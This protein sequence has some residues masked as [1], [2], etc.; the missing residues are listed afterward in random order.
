MT[1]LP[2]FGSFIP[3]TSSYLAT[4]SIQRPA[5]ASSVSIFST[6]DSRPQSEYYWNGSVIEEPKE[7]E[8]VANI[9]AGMKSKKVALG[10][11]KVSPLRRIR[12]FGS[13]SDDDSNGIE[14][15]FSDS[16]DLCMKQSP[17]FLGEKKK[18]FAH[19]PKRSSSFHEKSSDGEEKLGSPVS[20]FDAEEISA[21]DGDD[22]EQIQDSSDESIFRQSYSDF[23]KNFQETR[24]RMQDDL[25][26]S[27][28]LKRRFH[29]TPFATIACEYHTQLHARCP[30]N[31][32]ERR[33]AR[34]HP[35]S[36]KAKV[37]EE[38][39]VVE[40][41]KQDTLRSSDSEMPL[42]L[43]EDEDYEESDSK[44]SHLSSSKKSRSN[45]KNPSSRSAGRTGRKYLPQA[46][47]R[48]KLLHAKCPANCPDR[49]ARDHK[50]LGSQD[51]IES[52]C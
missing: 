47:D 48:H 2:F 43:D 35:R 5:F 7:L 23:V 11:E 15:T 37:V 24:S 30:P 39:F 42:F 1:T 26:C 49:L 25:S 29:G 45:K 41:K 28:K 22:Q 9:L 10:D 40:Q 31:C 3:E 8:L 51:M 36:K 50:L 46:C 6:V 19:S 17:E 38:D 4:L 16:D 18:S 33:P 52:D 32:P 12:T 13:D 34:P 21:L 44:S 20:M 14:E 27:P